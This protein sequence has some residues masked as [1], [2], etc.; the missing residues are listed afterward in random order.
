MFEFEL[1]VYR[2]R[3][4][5][6]FQNGTDSAHWE[7]YKEVKVIDQQAVHAEMKVALVDGIRVEIETFDDWECSADS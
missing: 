2:L 3:F 4:W 1:I 6:R 7:L 5:Q